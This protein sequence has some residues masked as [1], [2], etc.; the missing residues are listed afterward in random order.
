MVLILDGCAN[1]WFAWDSAAN[2]NSQ[3]YSNAPSSGWKGYFSLNICVTEYKCQY[4]IICKFYK[5]SKLVLMGHKV[6][7]ET[8]DSHQG[9]YIRW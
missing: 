9:T 1:E 3:K 6:L 2:G 4:S 7:R 8:L 5:L